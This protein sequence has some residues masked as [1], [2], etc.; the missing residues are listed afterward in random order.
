MR[1]NSSVMLRSPVIAPTASRTGPKAMHGV[2]AATLFIGMVALLWPSSWPSAN[3]GWI[4]AIQALALIE[5]LALAALIGVV[6]ATR[7]PRQH[8]RDVAVA[9]A[10]AGGIATITMLHALGGWSSLTLALVSGVAALI[11]AWMATVIAMLVRPSA[12][13]AGL[14][15]VT[16]TAS[17]LLV[18]GAQALIGG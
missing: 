13:A 12:G 16:T 5:L 7:C 17:L 1:S 2:I 11:I 15:A 18:V 6:T 9:W 10:V 4:V 3:S 8:V 14:G